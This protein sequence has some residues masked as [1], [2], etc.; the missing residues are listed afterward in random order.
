MAA[1]SPYDL[2]LMDIFMPGID[3]MET[4][5]RI[6]ALPGAASRVPIVALTANVSAQ[7]RVDY[8]ESGMDDL[9][10]KPV[11]RAELLA[12]LAHHA[13]QRRTPGVAAK[14]PHSPPRPRQEEKPTLDTARIDEWRRGLPPAVAANLFEECLRQLRDMLPAL[15][16]GLDRRD[17]DA[18]KR[19]THAM[20]GAAGNYGLASLEAMARAIGARGGPATGDRT[21][22]AAVMTIEIDRAERAIRALPQPALA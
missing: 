2:V 1:R 19:V 13:W 10:S 3:G 9:V 20:A 12:A 18:I 8:I 7:D 22:D 14:P 21:L 6:R 16:A 17:T 15:E 5:R 11:N 4:S